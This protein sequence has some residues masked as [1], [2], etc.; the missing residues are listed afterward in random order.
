[1][2]PL[3]RHLEAETD[4]RC[5]VICDRCDDMSVGYGD[6]VAVSPEGRIPKFSVIVFTSETDIRNLRVME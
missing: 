6:S 2:L 3:E 4:K 5:A 1:M